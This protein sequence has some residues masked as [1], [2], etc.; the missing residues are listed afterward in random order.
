MLRAAA[1]VEFPDSPGTALAYV[2][3]RESHCD[4]RSTWQMMRYRIPKWFLVAVSG[5]PVG[6]RRSWR[7]CLLEAPP[8]RMSAKEEDAKTKTCRKRATVGIFDQAIREIESLHQKSSPTYFRIWKTPLIPDRV[9]GH[10]GPV[11]SKLRRS[12]WRQK[13]LET[14]RA[15]YLQASGFFTRHCEKSRVSP[16]NLVRHVFGSRRGR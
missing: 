14:T 4:S 1:P 3:T 8:I 12:G 11:F 2:V 7:S 6:C 15:A 5:R 9:V 16:R 10:N 13:T